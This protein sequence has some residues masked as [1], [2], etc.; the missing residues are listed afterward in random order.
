MLPRVRALDDQLDRYVAATPS[1]RD[2]FVDLLRV[3]A[4]GVVVLWHW[5]LSVTHR[6]DG[7][8]VM[9]NPIDVVPGG[10][11][12]TWL[13]Q[14]MPVFFIVG[15]FVDLAGWDSTRRRGQGPT[16][17]LRARARRLLLPPLAL[18]AV[19]AVF[20]LAGRLLIDGHRPVWTWGEV[21]FVPLW[22]LGAYAGVV[23]LTPVTARAH[24]WR[25]VATLAG[26]A[27]AIAVLDVGRFGGGIEVLGLVTSALVWIFAHQLGYLY[28]DGTLDAIGV[29]GQATL[30]VSAAGL[31]ASTTHLTVY[32]ASMVA[33]R[34]ATF[35]HMWPTTGAIALVALLQLG[36]AMLARPLA[37]RWLRRR[38][39][40]KAVIA[41]NAVVLTVFLWHMTAKVGFLG[42][43]EQLGGQ[44]LEE[45]TTTWWLQRPLWVVG[46]LLFLLPLVAIF[47]PLELQLRGG[48][49]DA[50]GGRDDE[51]DARDDEDR[52]AGGRR[53]EDTGGE[54]TREG[55]GDGR[56]VR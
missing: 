3:L 42:V 6:E 4:I 18:V 32:P 14:I 35:S 13:L 26:L 11:A 10:W 7:A 55:D 38:R 37:V 43:Y 33:T 20:E 16:A 31:L 50:G 12:A 8:L 5:T 46:P 1:D 23:A 52:D 9:P 49:D 39:V 47:G 17:F 30:A 51:G 48:G 22:F 25:P 54:V 40:W 53:D 2:R 15:G 21:V 41:A 27:T 34:D 45:P 44:L 36:L 29:R 56:S 19:W 28:R 24:R